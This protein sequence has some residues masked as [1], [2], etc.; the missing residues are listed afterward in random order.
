VSYATV[1]EIGSPPPSHSQGTFVAIKPATT[2]QRNHHEPEMSSN[3]TESLMGSMDA[4]V[5]KIIEFAEEI[6]EAKNALSRN[7]APAAEI[8]QLAD[9]FEFPGKSRSELIYYCESVLQKK[10][11]YCS[12]TSDPMLREGT[13]GRFDG[14]A[15]VH[16]ASLS[17]RLIADDRLN[18]SGVLYPV[19]RMYS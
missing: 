16:Q 12:S 10:V 8:Q 7:D 1:S 15:R 9:L 17:H 4:L 19:V 18:I 14:I 2:W 11:T 3:A 13:N 6:R 5:A